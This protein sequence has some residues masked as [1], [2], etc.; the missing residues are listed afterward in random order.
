MLQEVYSR[1]TGRP[2]AKCLCLAGSRSHCDNCTCASEPGFHSNARNARVGNHDWLLRSSIPIGWRLRSLCVKNRICSISLRFLIRNDLLRQLRD[3]H[4]RILLFF[5]CVI[6][7]RF[8]RIFYFACILFLI[9]RPCVRCMRLNGKRASVELHALSDR[10]ECV[11][12][13]EHTMTDFSLVL[14]GLHKTDVSDD[15]NRY[16]LILSLFSSTL[17][18]LMLRCNKLVGWLSGR[19]SVSDR[20]TFTGLHWTCS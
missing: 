19:T 9:P 1:I 11:K 20:R 12:T 3:L 5:A 15:T 8:L 16:A 18:A 13:S 10:T 14:I 6:F 17:S 7:L 2:I 4:L